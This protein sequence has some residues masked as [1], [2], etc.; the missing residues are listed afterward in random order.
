MGSTLLPCCE[1]K[2][3]DGQPDLPMSSQSPKRFRNQNQANQANNESTSKDVKSSQAPVMTNSNSI[4]SSD[5]KEKQE[6]YTNMNES[7]DQIRISNTE[8]HESQYG[9]IKNDEFYDKN[10]ISIQP[11]TGTTQEPHH[12]SIEHLRSAKGETWQ[13]P[14]PDPLEQQM[15]PG[16]I[17]ITD[18]FLISIKIEFLEVTYKLCDDFGSIFKPYLEIHMD[19]VPPI[20]INVYKPEDKDKLNSSSIS[21]GGGSGSL[22]LSMDINNSIINT[23]SSITPSKNS[24]F[25]NNGKEGKMFNFRSVIIL[26]F[27]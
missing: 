18:E 25:S 10:R 11:T 9:D 7:I 13:T 2:E 3:S 19:D 8:N 21:T 23:V 27:I 24:K 14:S 1:R 20:R 26:S 12:S 5:K 6:I 15:E 17:I 4:N 16:E 22:D